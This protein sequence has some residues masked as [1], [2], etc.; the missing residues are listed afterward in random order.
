MASK[1]MKRRVAVRPSA[2]KAKALARR[3]EVGSKGWS[4]GYKTLDELISYKRGYSTIVFSPAHSGKT[5]FALDQAVNLAVM[6]GLKVAVYLTEAGDP[7]EIVLEIAQTYMRKSLD[8]PQLTDEELDFAIDNFVDKYFYIICSG[9]AMFSITDLAYSVKETNEEF[10]INLDVL[11]IDHFSNLDKAEE[12][13]GFRIDEDVKFVIQKVNSMSKK[14]KLH[15]MI[16][17]HV[18]DKEPIKCPSSGMYYLGP[19]EPY[20]LVGGQNGYRLGYQMVAVYRPITHPSK[21]GIIDPATGAPYAVNET[22]VIVAKTKPKFT[23]KLG[24]GKLYWDAPTQSYK[25]MDEYGADWFSRE[26]YSEE[27]TFSKETKKYPTFAELYKAHSQEKTKAFFE[28][29]IDPTKEGGVPTKISI[30]DY[31]F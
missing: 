19:P 1:D 22:Q 23:G 16:L 25:E 27:D 29:A 24:T 6:Y 8:D 10:D 31:G 11:V 9:T 17:F 26:R 3:K 20:E 30:K 15:T 2:L 14:L 28:E 4:T 12:Q 18:R 21:Y 7:E 5:Q 13:R